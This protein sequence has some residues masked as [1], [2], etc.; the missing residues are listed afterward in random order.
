M[1][2]KRC[3]V[4]VDLSVI[5]DN[6][7]ILSLALEPGQEMMAVVKADAYGHGAVPVSLVLQEE[8]VCHFAVSNIREAMELREAG[9]AGQILIL[10]YTSASEA[11]KLKYYDITQTLISEEHALG[12]KG[13]GIKAQFAI[14]TGM[15]RIGLDGD[16]PAYCEA[17]IRAYKD[18]VQLTG[19]FTHLCTADDP[20]SDDFT[21]EQMA[22]FEAVCDRVSDLDLPYLHCL[23]SAGGLYHNAYGK[24]VR[25]GIVL[26]GLKPDRANVLP[27]GLKPAMTWKSLISMVKTVH[28]G[29]SISYGRTFTADHEMRVATVPVGYA[30][31]YRRD[32]SNQGS[33]WIRGKE[34]RILGR[35]CMDQFM[36]DVTDI[37][38]ASFEDEVILMDQNYNADTIA[39]L[40]RTI[41]YEIACDISK[42][43]ERVYIHGNNGKA[44]KF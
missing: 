5:R 22:R 10:G 36:C 35:V 17:V 12:F 3:Y 7:R 38:E 21:K 13:T 40:C 28:P 2:N 19:L 44:E 18:D 15:N 43:T 37:P 8:G 42:R 33:V 1:T 32:M 34:A 16:D 26:Y 23:N 6:A 14:D 29:E 31:G 41:G 30:D 4:E 11:D 24:L 9:I 25:F 27:E 39:A 20:S